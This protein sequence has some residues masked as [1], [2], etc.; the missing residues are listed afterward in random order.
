MKKLLLLLLILSSPFFVAA[1]SFTGRLQATG[2]VVL[3]QS[4][5]ITRLIDG[6]P[7]QS[8]AQQQTGKETSSTTA[9]ATGE[10]TASHSAPDD[11]LL[12]EQTL[13]TQKRYSNS[14]TVK[15]YRVQVYSGNNSRAARQQAQAA[16]QKVKGYM[17]DATVYTH[18]NSPTWLTRVGDF[19]TYEEASACLHTLRQTDDFK[20]A[21][22]V[23]CN[24][25]VS[26]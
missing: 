8:T 13:T 14:Y 20:N 2:R 6:A 21:I 17:P 24:I 16:A 7:K 23:S 1:Q 26:Y 25:R 3:H 5:A 15:G 18:F 9:T 19:R 12:G 10:E 11:I 4:A 22:I